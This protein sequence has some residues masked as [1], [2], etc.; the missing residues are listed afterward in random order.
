M[1]VDDAYNM[2]IYDLVLVP[3]A[4][5]GKG[6]SGQVWDA[7]FNQHINADA[8]E[9]V[10]FMREHSVR[11]GSAREPDSAPTMFRTF[12]HEMWTHGRPKNEFVLYLYL[13]V[14]LRT[15]YCIVLTAF[16]FAHSLV[17]T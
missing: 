5:V 12:Q 13:F 2:H 6:G 10:S 1:W 16:A 15:P 7:I 3:S 8:V 14:A 9:F 11:S 17:C 4:G